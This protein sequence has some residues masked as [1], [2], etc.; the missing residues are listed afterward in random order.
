MVETPFGRVFV[1]DAPGD[2]P[3]RNPIV[4]LHGFP[5]SSFDFH[6]VFDRLVATG[7]RVVLFDFLGFGFSDKPDRRYGID[8]H[9]DTAV[10]LL[11]MLGIDRF[12]LVTHDMGDSV[13]GELLARTMP[14][15]SV[16]DDPA[17]AHDAPGDAILSADGPP[18]PWAATITDRVITNG[19]IYLELAE[20]TRGQHM[21]WSAPDARLDP[22]T[23]TLIAAGLPGGLAQVCHAATMPDDQELEAQA[24]VVRCND[25]AALM[26][27]L[28]RYLDDRRRAEQRYTGAIE[29]HP[30]P[31][32]ILW[33]QNDPVARAPM[34]EQLG[35]RR[36]DAHLVRLE[37]VGHYPM[38][39]APEV[40]G[41][42]LIAAL[43]S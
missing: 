37:G 36:A 7:R 11:A 43:D 41:G 16:P 5:T 34:G 30:S 1:V 39:E 8:L 18:A 31:L 17:W 4:V 14:A 15:G 24:E 28:I 42:A 25:G 23:A 26:P 12:T 32:T 13:G 20:L 6:R 38:V 10:A 19:S 9:A 27:R 2:D 3:A 33:A 22:D 40:F 29:T 21:L 35:A